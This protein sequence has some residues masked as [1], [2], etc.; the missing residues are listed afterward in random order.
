MTQPE[1]GIDF[2]SSQSTDAP[3]P[4]GPSKS[5]IEHEPFDMGGLKMTTFDKVAQ[6]P[7]AARDLAQDAPLP[8]VG[9]QAPTISAYGGPP[10][11]GEEPEPF[12]PN[13]LVVGDP[14]DPRPTE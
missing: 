3:R 11:A 5:G 4:S 1:G 8:T 6:G 12:D 10:P 14:V 7:A 2:G 13:A 9:S